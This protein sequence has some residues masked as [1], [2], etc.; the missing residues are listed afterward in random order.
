MT[1][2]HRIG[3]EIY[4]LPVLEVRN[5]KWVLQ[6]KN[7]D[8]SRVSSFWKLEGR[9]H[10]LAFLLLLETV[11]I[12]W[13]MAPHTMVFCHSTRLQLWPSRLPREDPCDYPGLTVIITDAVITS[14]LT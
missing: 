4:S 2:Y 8:L 3:P 10:F 6:G 13:L 12:P 9:I 5:L 14:S 11:L 1:N 7:Q